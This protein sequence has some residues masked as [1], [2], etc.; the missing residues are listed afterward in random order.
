[1]K[2]LKN[3]FLFFLIFFVFVG[4][5]KGADP[6]LAIKLTDSITVQYCTSPVPI[7]ESLTIEGNFTLTGMKIS[8]NEGFNAAED[9]LV[10]SGLIGNIV[11]TWYAYQGF[12]LLQGDANTTVDNYRDAVKSVRYKNKN[13]IPTLGTRKISITLE[14]ADYLWS[15]GH[16]YRFISKSGIKWT[17]AEAEAK[18]D[19]MKYYG[20]RGYLATITDAGENYFIKTKTKGVG[21]IGASDAAVEGDW[22]WVTGPEGLMDSGKVFSSGK[23]QVT[24]LK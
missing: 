5:A 22:R 14:D 20:L 13:L 10:Y 21:W 4:V 6:V 1:M 18:S 24:R 7:A 9:E 3:L 11:G 23:V 15:T 17:E 2:Q 8:I 19:A 16:F 12:L